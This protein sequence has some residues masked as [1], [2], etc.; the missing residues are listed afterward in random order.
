MK[1]R[2]YTQAELDRAVAAEREACRRPDWQLRAAAPTIPGFLIL[3]DCD[4]TAQGWGKQYELVHW[5]L[6]APGLGGYWSPAKNREAKF[7]R[8]LP[9]PE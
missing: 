5:V 4:W 6:L 7:E 8:W 2:L 1:E 3:A 9:L